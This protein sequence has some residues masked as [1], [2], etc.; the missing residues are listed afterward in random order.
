MK[1]FQDLLIL[2]AAVAAGIAN[3]PASDH[4]DPLVLNPLNPPRER[5][6][7]ITDLHVFLDRDAD[8]T[9]PEAREL[10][11]CLSVFPS[12]PALER[13]E[14]V[15]PAAP[16]V[17]LPLPAQSGEASAKARYRYPA[18]RLEDYRYSICL[19][20]HP[21]LDYG[22]AGDRARY[23]GT[24]LAPEDI[25]PELVLQFALGND[26]SLQPQGFRL[27]GL[28]AGYVVINGRDVG[29]PPGNQRPIRIQTGV[30]DDPFIFPRFF[31]T[32][33]IAIVVSIP[34]DRFAPQQREFLAWAT[35]T[36]NGRQIDHVGRSQRTQLPRFD[37]L[38]TLPPSRHVAEINRRHTEPTL[39]ED[40]MRTFLSPLFARR[41]YD[42][43]P[44]VLIFDRS[45]PARFPNG[46]RLDDDVAAIIQQSGDTQLWEASYTDDPRYPRQTVNDKR[47]GRTFP[48]LATPW[49][50]DEVR[51]DPRPFTLGR[52]TLDNRS[53][54]LLWLLESLAIAG[55]T[56]VLLWLWR[57]AKA[58][59]AVLALAVIALL[60][61]QGVHEANRP[62][63]E[64]SS[65]AMQ[66][67]HRKLTIVLQSGGLAAAL[68]L[69]CLYALAYRRGAA[70]APARESAGAATGAGPIP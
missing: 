52:A 57:P 36:R 22:H 65:A 15:P 60:R 7:R 19:D 32:N 9:L 27:T 25:V 49:T 55:L 28:A 54:R 58:R 50:Q 33:V 14:S 20:L 68:A 37:G 64:T 38:N 47:F 31:R 2:L 56:S 26:A 59:L 66:Q 16:G 21:R 63:A 44:D 18:F 24:V 34:L 45:R 4:A 17:T 53:W 69:A 42:A 1:R 13:D 5:E 30:F 70:S 8:P 6:P 43:M 67:P 62:D 11:L 61:L 46:R 41:P 10:I 29:L 35:T 3:L 48:Y 40:G 39:M 51:A 23:G 12:L